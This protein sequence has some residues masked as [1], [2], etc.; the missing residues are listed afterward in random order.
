MGNTFNSDACGDISNPPVPVATAQ[1]WIANWVLR[2]Q[3]AFPNVTDPQMLRGFRIP[4]TDV[5]HLLNNIPPNTSPNWLRVYLY[6]KDPCDL[7]SV[8]VLILAV[9]SDGN[10]IIGSDPNNSLI[11]DF[12]CP[13]PT[14][15]GGITTLQPPLSASPVN[16]C[17]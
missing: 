10:D 8:G 17:P 15:C 12:T 13:C 16:P 11:Y 7:S 3:L 5:N 6:L 9:D 1:N 2:Y 14:E 4:M